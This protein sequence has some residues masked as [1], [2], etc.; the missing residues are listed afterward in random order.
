MIR[1]KYGGV[2]T[3][4]GFEAISVHYHRILIDSLGLEAHQMD[5]A[6]W[7]GTHN[8]LLRVALPG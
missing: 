3:A 1:N 5:Y 7:Y 8:K 2:A 4:K 6:S